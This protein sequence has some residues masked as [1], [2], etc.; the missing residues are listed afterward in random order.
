MNMHYLLKLLSNKRPVFHSEADFQHALAWEVHLSRQSAS[1]RLE[2]QVATSS[3]PVHLDMLVNDSQCHVAVELKYKTKSANLT[4][5]G[6][7]FYLR[8]HSAQ[9]L[10]CYYFL[11]DIVRIENYTQTYSRSE[12]YAVFLT[13]DST[14]WTKSNRNNTVSAAFRIY[15]GR[16]IKGKLEWDTR[17]SIAS[18]NLPSAINIRGSY[19]LKWHDFSTVQQDKFRYLV[20]HVKSNSLPHFSGSLDSDDADAIAEDINRSKTIKNNDLCL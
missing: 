8:N 10:G 20:V 7:N 18:S 13:N 3:R 2:K 19:T 6:E 4:W 1:I 17:A 11:K 9:N 5:N 16:V 12:G 15:E 14:Y